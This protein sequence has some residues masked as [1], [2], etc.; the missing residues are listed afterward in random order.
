MVPGGRP[1]IDIGHKYNA[2]KVVYFIV[3]EDSGI[4]KAGIPY[5]YKYPDL[6]SNVFIIPVYRHLVMSKFFVSVNGIDP[7]KNQGSL[8]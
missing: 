4:T 2:C 1:L 6:F 5:L 8:I 7:Q 3:I